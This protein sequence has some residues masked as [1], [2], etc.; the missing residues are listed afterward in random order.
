[1]Q[2]QIM[3]SPSKRASLK[4]LLAA[5]AASACLG[6][7]PMTA[8]A[9]AWAPGVT[10]PITPGTGSPTP[11]PTPTTPSDEIGAPP[12]DPD[13]NDAPVTA[14]S[15]QPGDAKTET[16]CDDGTDND[17][18]T[19][20]DCGD[21]DCAKAAVCQT[22]GRPEFTEE[23]CHD[24]LDN[25]RD[26]AFDC[27]DSDCSDM[28]A[29]KGSWDRAPAAAGGAGGPGTHNGLAAT[30]IDHSADPEDLLGKGQDADGERSEHMCSDGYDN[31]HDGKTDCEDLG[32]RL[33]TSVVNC[34]PATNFRFSV[35]A[36]TQGTYDVQEKKANVEFSAIQLRVLGQIPYI[37]NSFFLLS[38]R[39][40]K[41][42]RLVF[43]IFQVPIKGGHYFNL[44]SGSGSLSLELVRSIHKRLLVDPAFYMLNGF[45]QGNGAAIEFGGPMDKRGKF[46]YRTFLAG[47]SGRFAGNVG[48]TFFPDNNNN[49]TYTAGAQ[50]WM[51]LIG[52]YNR[53]DSPI[54][55]TPAPT[56]LSLAVG[57]KYDQRSQERY[58][59]ANIQA[60]FRYR[61]LILLGEAYGKRE[62]N[63]G[64]YQLAYN[65]QVGVL[66]IKKRLLLSGDFGQYLATPFERPPA[67]LGYD[68]RRQNQEMQY[69]AAAHVFLWRELFML[70]LIWG[71]R[72]VRSSPLS[73]DAAVVT[74]EQ[75]LRLVFQYR[76]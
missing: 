40:E 27:D 9:H 70:T 31:D 12:S 3:Q 63:F 48:G 57:A 17:G 56:T 8:A 67:E 11:G 20:Y 69:R 55:Y 59:A 76:F 29:C 52:Y 74:K 16:I 37:Q 50:I 51:N 75:S 41:T 25:D 58:P 30:G 72:R 6:L 53:Y 44:N 38:F 13:Q 61:R 54:L 19:V 22:D 18:D 62:L 45:E 39:A 5:L 36:R 71:D 42:P 49:F 14:T 33:D 73:S 26:G 7:A 2:T 23:R 24:W 32:C 1:M 10:T 66:P 65:I 15:R 34:Q 46:L 60:T 43:A 28:N 64:S 68:L 35:V 4:S 47:G 21:N